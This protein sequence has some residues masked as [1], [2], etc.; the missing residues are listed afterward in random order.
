MNNTKRT[1]IC[2]TTI[3]KDYGWTETLIEKFL[4]EPMLK[5]NYHGHSSPPMKLYYED[6]V[7]KIMNTEEFKAELEKVNKR[8]AAVQ[9]GIDRKTAKALEEITPL[10]ETITVKVIPEKKVVTWAIWAQ[11]WGWYDVDEDFCRTKNP[12]VIARW[13]VSYIRKNLIDYD[14]R[15][16]ELRY[17]T[18]ETNR[19]VEKEIYERIAAA[20]PAYADECRRQI[21]DLRYSLM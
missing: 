1:R 10:L 7:Q 5:P 9:K 2:K 4:P 20:Y 8:R 16:K 18:D 15:L 11:G 17:E 6:E 13:A 21:D 12:E 14:Q 3:R 19:V